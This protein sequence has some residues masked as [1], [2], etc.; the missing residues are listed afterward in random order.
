MTTAIT[1]ELRKAVEE[2]MI[3]KNKQLRKHT[4]ENVYLGKFPIMVQSDFCLLNNMPPDLRFNMG[5][6][7]HDKGGYFI[8]QG[9]EKTIISQEKFADNVLYVKKRIVETEEGKNQDIFSVEIKVFLKMSKPVRRL[10]VTIAEDGDMGLAKYTNKNIL[11]SIPKYA[12][13]FHYLLC[14]VH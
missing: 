3:E 2:S 6:C 5:E 14:F 1:S 9:K 10:F 8:I 13:L 4:Y 7:K 12:C 11:V